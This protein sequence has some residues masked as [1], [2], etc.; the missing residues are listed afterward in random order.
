MRLNK[1]QS[2]T[3]LEWRKEKRETVV[4]FPLYKLH[5]PVKAKSVINK[6]HVNV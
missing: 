5:Q 2:I 3:H 6:K 1:I 4:A